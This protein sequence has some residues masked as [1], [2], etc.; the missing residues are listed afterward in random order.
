MKLHLPLA[1]RSS[2]YALFAACTTL[3]PAQAGIM[4]SDATLITYTDFGQNVGRYK[5]MESANALLQHIRQ[6]EGGVTITYTGGQQ[7]YVMPHGMIDFGSTYHVA[8]CAAISPSAIATVAHNYTFDSWF[9]NKVYGIGMENAVKYKGIELGEGVGDTRWNSNV[10]SHALS[11]SIGNATDHRVMRLSKVITDAPYAE[12]YDTAGKDLGSLTYYHAGSGQQWR[13][14]YN[15]TT[16]V[17]RSYPN[18]ASQLISAYNYV[19]GGI[20]SGAAGYAG[21]TGFYSQEYFDAGGINASDPLTWVSRPGDSGSPLYVWDDASGTYQ[22]IGSNRGEILSGQVGSAFV[23][24][25][26]FDK[27]VVEE[28]YTKRVNMG[29]VSEVYLNAV[30]TQGETVTDNWG[31]ST[32][33]WLG[34]V[35]GEGMETV[36][37]VGLKSGLNTWSDLSGLKDTQNWY[38]Y[39][40]SYV[41]QS[42]QDLFFTENLV[43]NATAEEN[44]IIVAGAVDLGIGYAEFNG[45]KFTISS[46]E[47]ERNLFNHAGY[48]INEGAEVHL[49]LTN[50]AEYMRE[51]R[52]IG[53]GDLYIEGSGNNDVLLNLGG[54][55]KTYLNREGGY[56]A[57]NVLV[58]T[59]ATVVISDAGQIKRDLTFGNRGGTLDMNGNSMDWYTAAEAADSTRAGFSINALTEDALVANYS[60]SSTLTYKEAGNTAYAGSFADSA[61]SSLKIIYDE[62]EGTWTLNSIRTNLQHSDSGLQVDSGTVVLRGTN[63]IHGAGSAS[64]LNE[65]RYS[66]EDDWHYAD[67]AM[68][69]TVTDGGT[70]E[71]GSHAR[72]TGNVTVA[73]GGTYV[74]REG[75][76]H[77]MEYVEGGQVLEDTGKYAAYFGHKGD[78]VLNGGTF[79]VQFNEGVDSTTSYAGSVTGTGAMTVD[80]GTD[81]GTFA[82]SGTVDAGVSKTL[83]RGQL[84]LS[85]TAAADTTNKWLVNAGGVMVQFENAADTLGVIDAA[86][87]GVLGLNADTTTPLD[88][89][90]HSQLRIGALSG[91]L[92]QYG[93]A[94]T[95]EKLTT[96]NLGG[97]GK[98]VV[99]YALSGSDTLNVNAG[100]MRGGEINL[101]N[102]AADYCGTVNVQAAGGSVSL[103]T[104]TEGSFNNATVNV[105]SG[106]IYRLTDDQ[107]TLGGTLNVNAGGLLQGKDMVLRGKDGVE[108]AQNYHL[109]LSGKMEYD[110]FTVE[111][112][113]TL[114]LREGGRLD[115][116]NAA[117]I[118]QGGIMRLNRQTLQDKV[119][120]KNGGTIY[121]NGGTIGASANVQAVEGTGKLNAGSGTFKVNGQIGAA[122]GATLR[123]EN[124]TFNIY[125]GSVNADGGTIELACSTV[126]LGH[127]V[128]YATQNIGGTLSI[129]ND[130]TINADQTSTAYQS[131][132]H[133]IDHLHIADGHKLT[134]NDPGSSWNHIY[135]ISLLT[136][137]GT[138]QWNSNIYWYHAGTSR[139]VLSGDNSF[140]GTLIVNQQNNDGSMQHVSLAHENA[141]KNMVINLWGDGDSRPGLAISTKAARVAGIGGTTNTFV[142]AG[143]VKTAGNGDNPASSALNT[144]IINTGDANHTYNGTLLGNATHGLNIVKD[145]TGTQTFTNA[146]NVVHDVTALQGHLEFT[147][148]PTIH[149]D[150]SIAQGAQLTIGNGAYTLDAGETLC[151]M[152]GETGTSAI[153]NNDLVINGGNLEFG[154]YN[155][156]GSASL[157]LGGGH[158]L[159]VAAGAE[160]CISFSNR[161]Q[162]KEQNAFPELPPYLL[163]EGD[164]SQSKLTVA[165]CRYLNVNLTADTSGLYASFNLK[166][167]YE[168][169]MGDAVEHWAPTADNVV[170]T[171]LNPFSDVINLRSDVTIKNGILDNDTA[172]VINS[173]NENTLHFNSVEKIAHGDLVI[174]TAVTANSFTVRDDTR[175][176]GTGSL[177]VSDEF[178]ILADLT[179]GMEVETE[180]V[181][182]REGICWTLD[183][184]ERAFTQNLTLEQVN[185]IGNFRVEGDAVLGI[186]VTGSQSITARIEG[187]GKTSFSGGGTLSKD[188]ALSLNIGDASLTKLTLKGGGTTD[189]TGAVTL[190]EHLSIGKETLNIR[191]NA[192]VTAN[193]LTA[194]NEADYSP[195]TINIDGGELR[196]T[197]TANEKNTSASL[198]LAHWKESASVM[199]LNAG[200]LV[201][202]NTIM[203]TSWDTAGTFRALGGEAELLGINLQGNQGREGAFELGTQDAGTA[204]VRLGGQGIKG[205]VGTGRVSLGNGTIVATGDFSIE[206]TNAVTMMGC[207]TGTV[208]DTAGHNIT[209]KTSLKEEEGAKIVKQG[210]GTL[211]LEAANEVSGTMSVQGGTLQLSGTQA[212]RHYEIQEGATLSLTHGDS[213]VDVLS[214]SGGG[215]LLKNSAGDMNMGAAA[216]HR[217]SLKGGGVSSITGAVSVAGQLSIGRETVNLLEGAVVTANRLTAGNEADYSPSTINIDG[218]ELRITG[219]ANEKNT[220]ASLLLAHWKESASVMNL[221]AGKLVA[222]NTIMYTSWDTAGTFRALGGEAELL[223]INLQGQLDGRSGSFVLGGQDKGTAVV[224]IGGQGIKGIVGTAS[225]TLGNGRL[226]AADDFSIEGANGVSLVGTNGGTTFDT[227]GH[228][229]TVNTVMQGEGKLVVNGSGTLKLAHSSGSSD[230]SDLSGTGKFVKDGAGKLNLHKASLANAT[231]KGNGTT[232]ISGDVS[233]T[234]QLDFGTEKVILASGADVTT[235]QLRL[236]T[237]DREQNTSLSI[238]AGATLNI[239]GTTFTDKEGQDETISLLL[240]HWHDSASTLVLNGGTLNASGTTMHMGWDSGG[241]FQAMSGVANLKGILFSTTRD[242]ADRFILGSEMSGTARVNIGSAGITG[243]SANDTVQLGDGTIQA[244]DDFVISGSKSVVLNGTTDK[245]TVFD[246]NGHTIT[247]QAAMDSEVNSALTI[248]NGTLKQSGDMW[249]DRMHVAEGASFVKDSVEV[250]GQSAASTI[251]KSANASGDKLLYFNDGNHEIQNA[252]VK[253]EAADARELKSQLTHSTV[254]NAGSGHLTVSNTANRLSGVVASGG[255]MAL[256]HMGSAM[257]LELLEIAAGKTVNAYVGDNTSTKITTTTVTD[258]AIL[259]GTA[260]LNTCLI[261]AD[262][263]TLEMRGLEAGAV[264]LSGALTFGAGLQMGESLLASV[265]AL[266]YGETLNLFTGLSGV[267]L[268]V[269][270]D[271]ESSRVLASSV[272]SNV[273]SDTLYVDYR[274]IDNVGTLLVANV[275]EPATATLSLMAL[276]A[277]AA[278]RRR[279]A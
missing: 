10:F 62:A 91:T 129:V 143:A 63:T 258:S 147:T 99:N 48:V 159:S 196:I 29:A 234:G 249:F 204:V 149:G 219:T 122:E 262:G 169:W 110:S 93:A 222:A 210:A 231:F 172:V 53:A 152:Q 54:S 17:D 118:G 68:N 31:R 105:N 32:T 16:L 137:D 145:G 135:N 146:A 66:H 106:G 174:N 58:N 7:T 195:S 132:T 23:V 185:G 43:F 252:R 268:P 80:A 34:T 267:N 49:Q 218:G 273:Q 136:G 160:V 25:T 41:A 141:A 9:S 67:A 79:A 193:R 248:Q 150:V 184:S 47:G 131:P 190:S 15:T 72:L 140:S 272:F 52:K 199:N 44:L 168:Y 126:N 102:V 107:H 57:Y 214:V 264:T 265:G 142:Y 200:K 8:T 28:R 90:S 157:V 50:P 278:R 253:V 3:A 279:K 151:V 84:Q 119:D 173:E 13:S 260:I 89:S 35:T 76:R 212:A 163:V 125:S 56:A 177:N 144:L 5:T 37:F 254:E 201:A 274:V 115:A 165:D 239:S 71:L 247:V 30:S 251:V 198:L 261:L 85:G 128:N 121:G 120:L 263:A 215:V 148:A 206:G 242:N 223:G 232:T 138:I 20:V 270:V 259:S 189:M 100:T 207:A 117:T 276:S 74:M 211:H 127:K 183:G 255:D 170:I 167:G 124:G 213:H 55:G 188:A 111:N 164:W 205:I 60:G 1:L 203:Y 116:A 104:G 236:G 237:S 94:G 240:A 197:G 98:L 155:E 11:T 161:C 51:W 156:N 12:L 73:S 81:G 2:L 39:G 134:L 123:L 75:V 86:S 97:G 192:V 209:V 187:T 244:M 235:N 92:V 225:V 22:Y 277:L 109:E 42:N 241:T 33:K 83:N 45:G 186:T 27:Q 181:L 275:P 246:A 139:M 113:A 6:Q 82:F 162:I 226:A 46:A 245:G 182:Y 70:F 77:T 112:G 87:T 19:I 202:A 130:V 180:N 38:T 243:F 96:L 175:I 194:G 224:I 40:E 257:S 250:I 221:N 103:T 14:T 101:Q 217:L 269:V 95:S 65:N 26:T 153:W 133:N 69:V 238:E 229:I 228:T 171:G 176:S 227:A 158:S 59:G 61:D 208:F 108:E 266:D 114:N 4:H 88:L 256:H 230:I 24:D 18:N 166:D 154:A 64:G 36:S 233:I 179:T 191:K 271:T 21:T 216:L 220:S 78:V 178:S